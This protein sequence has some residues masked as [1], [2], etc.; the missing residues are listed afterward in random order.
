M[1]ARA[2][3]SPYGWSNTVTEFLVDI[4]CV[5]QIIL[6]SKSTTDRELIA[7]LRFLSVRCEFGQN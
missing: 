3:W 1:A 5:F 6:T 7:V 4:T 2:F